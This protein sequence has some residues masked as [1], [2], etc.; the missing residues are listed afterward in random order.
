MNKRKT[1]RK[2]IYDLVV[3]VF[4]VML[5]VYLGLLVNNWNEAKNDK[6]KT[7]IIL[8]NLL[9][10]V[11]HNKSVIEASI[12]YFQELADSI[13]LMKDKSKAP[14]TFS[15]WKG[16][17]PPVL[18]NSSFQ[19]AML[20]GVVT[21]FEIELIELLSNTYSLQED[22]KTQSDTYIQSITDKIGN[23]SFNNR[24]YLIILENYAHDQVAAEQL[25]I[26]ELEKAKSLLSEK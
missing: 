3:M 12:V 17:N 8:N 7:E 5:G 19:T 10:E 1:I 26:S 18:K 21:N 4:P 25:L 15:F 23:E 20:T 6:K 9:S 16:L 13:Y 24:Q 22:L 14:S 2:V 11:N